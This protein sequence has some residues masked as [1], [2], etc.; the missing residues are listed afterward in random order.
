MLQSHFIQDSFCSVPL[1]NKSIEVA[2]KIKDNFIFY[3]PGDCLFAAA[4][5][6]L[7]S[8]SGM[9]YLLS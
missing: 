7:I 9:L 8:L 1:T 6:F 3:F 2:R 4:A 5:L